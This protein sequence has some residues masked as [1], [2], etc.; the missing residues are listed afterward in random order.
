MTELLYI[1][2]DLQRRIANM[3]KRGKVHSVDVSQSPP[4]VRVEYDQG[5]VT[6]WLPWVSGR[7]SSQHRCDWEPLAVGEQVMI[8]SESG[9]LTAGVVIPA[10]ADSASPVP[11]KSTDEHVSRYSDGTEIHY[12]RGAHKLTITMGSGGDAELNC[13]T[14]FINGDIEHN[15]KQHSTGNIQSDRNIIDKTRSMGAD[16]AIFNRHVH[17][18]PESGASTSQPDE[19]Q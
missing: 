16:R 8:L 18:S 2:R 10:I 3:I 15:G 14:F 4:R 9:E 12:H 17:R 1:V 5:A 7:A 6:G 13:N 11:S 19:K